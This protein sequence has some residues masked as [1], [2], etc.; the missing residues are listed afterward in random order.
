MKDPHWFQKEPNWFFEKI[1]I[2]D[3]TL[4]GRT[5]T[6]RQ[7]TKIRNESGN[8]QTN[9]TEIKRIIRQYYE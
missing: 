8:V 4:A 2:S 6:K 7:V 5:K 9:V 1:N 3:K